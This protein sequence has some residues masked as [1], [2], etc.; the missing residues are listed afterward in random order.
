MPGTDVFDEIA[1][2]KALPSASGDVF[3]SLAQSSTVN[4][5]GPGGVRLA[6]DKNAQAPTPAQAIPPVPQPQSTLRQI[7]SALT[8]PLLNAPKNTPLEQFADL[9]QN[10]GT[11]TSAAI[12]QFLAGTTG[13]IGKLAASSTS[14]LGIGMM[15]SGGGLPSTL[16]GAGYGA[17]GATQALKP[18]QQ[19]ETQADALQR[20]LFGS[21]MAVGGMAGVGSKAK[22]ALGN[23]FAKVYG[24]SPEYADQVADQVQ[25][26]QTERQSGAQKLESAKQTLGTQQ[27]QLHE[28]GRQIIADA[29]QAVAQ[30]QARVQEPFEKI[31][32]QITQPVS[33]AST[34]RKLIQS[35]AQEYGVNP[36]EIPGAATKALSKPQT[37]SARALTGNELTMA[38]ALQNNPEWQRMNID[39]LQQVLPN[40][41]YAPQQIDAILS[42]ARPGESV[43]GGGV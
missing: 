7:G 10:Y 25:K 9:E 14:P 37:S 26:I 35:T 29:T 31:A 2:S 40:L 15:A 8:T 33:D 42:V 27:K 22:D 6:V 43:S 16:I 20:K 38:Q 23:H 3:D 24:L 34:I 1:P 39:Q 28:T 32:S 17:Y 36:E 41:G 12:A 30:E 21:A 13:D 19:G 5:I 18:Q 4:V 11:P